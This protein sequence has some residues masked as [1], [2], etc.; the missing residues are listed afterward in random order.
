MKKLKRKSGFTLVECIVAMA[1]LVIMTLLLSMI[2]TASINTRNRNMN[3]EREIDEQIVNLVQKVGLDSDAQT[4]SIVFKQGADAI[5]KIPQNGVDGMSADKVYYDNDDV[6]IGALDYNFSSFN[7]FEQI[8]KGLVKKYTPDGDINGTVTWKKGGGDGSNNTIGG[9]TKAYGAV[10]SSQITISQTSCTESNGI[11][12]VVLT[13]EFNAASAGA[14]A[15]NEKALKVEIP[16]T[17]ISISCNDLTNCSSI[18]IA[19]N[20]ARIEP[21]AAGFVEASITFEISADS[22]DNDFKSVSNFYTGLGNGS[23]VTLN[24]D[25]NPESDTYCGYK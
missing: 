8:S 19:T 18:P 1:V 5:D 15:P 21:T 24:K 22:F 20:L 4:D 25:T 10:D 12:K 16:A 3:I 14:I 7:D 23:S 13:V 11:K 6:E 17:A 2:L 9:D